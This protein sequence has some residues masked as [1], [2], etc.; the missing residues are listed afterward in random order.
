MPG[1]TRGYELG[2]FFG[3]GSNAAMA[4]TLTATALLLV[5]RHDP[6]AVW[7]FVLLGLFLFPCYEYAVHRWILHARPM[8]SGRIY[9]LQRLIHYDHHQDP[10]RIDRL[11]T[12]FFLFLPLI[13]LH[14]LLYYLVSRSVPVTLALLT[15]SLLGYLHYEWVH[16]VAHRPGTP[17]TLWGRWLKRYHLRHHYKNERY[18]FGVTTP[19]V[20]MLMRTDPPVGAVEKSSTTRQLYETPRGA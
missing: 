18:W 2:R 19:L 13:A 4:A 14:G 7:P 10:D 17:R 20:D 1:R 6:R 15:G 12:P 11:F 5:L 9:R 16:Y 3:H 8:G